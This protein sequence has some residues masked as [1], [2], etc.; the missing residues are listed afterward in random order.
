[1][2]FRVDADSKIG[3]GH[4][5]RC[6]SLAEENM[7]HGGKTLFLSATMPEDVSERCH[8]AGIHIQRVSET[9][10]SAEDVRA[11]IEALGDFLP[12]WLIVDGY[13]FGPEF[14][15]G[16]KKAGY[17]TVAIDDNGGDRAAGAGVI[18]N[19]NLHADPA[20]YPG[21]RGDAGLLLGTQYVLLRNEFH[22]H[23]QEE[24]QP[25][26]DKPR[27]LVTM[28]GGDLHNVTSLVVR[29]LSHVEEPLIDLTVIV[30]P[31]F[32][33]SA[34]KLA[35]GEERITVVSGPANMADW[36]SWADF[37][38][39]AAGSTCWE[40][41]YMGVPS[42]L[43]VTAKNQEP[44]ARAMAQAGVA[45]DLGWYDRLTGTSVA[46]VVSELAGDSERLA[47]MAARGRALV[48]GKGSRRVLDALEARM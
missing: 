31:T 19:Q 35:A 39:A 24:K 30:S 3:I 27:V 2:A 44:M 48:D 13:T 6:L 47:E 4:A 28:G 23:S 26:H 5:M 43:V 17:R 32:A 7:E 45:V 25:D 40:L 12:D 16:L 36:F 34:D 33:H 37:T 10:G 42:G 29:A 21:N 1:M 41:A 46:S 14:F 22:T 18:L 38:V 15:L 9:P 8:R 11:T 20:L